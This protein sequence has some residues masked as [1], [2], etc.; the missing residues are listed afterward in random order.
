MLHQLRWNYKNLPI[1]F[2]KILLPNCPVLT[3]NKIEGWSLN[4]LCNVLN[5]QIMLSL[6]PSSK[7][8]KRAFPISSNNEQKPPK[9]VNKTIVQKGKHFLPFVK[10]RENGL[11]SDQFQVHLP[12]HNVPLY[13]YTLIHDKT[14]L[15]WVLYGLHNI[16][17]KLFYLGHSIKLLSFFL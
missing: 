5:G 15:L 7:F 17:W 4:L 11:G 16:D 10:E 8:E 1:D 2:D 6:I 14:A 9:Y 3:L 12:Y 13:S